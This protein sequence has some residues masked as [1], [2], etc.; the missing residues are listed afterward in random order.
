[1]GNFEFVQIYVNCQRFEMKSDRRFTNGLKI[2]LDSS[3]NFT[4]ITMKRSILFIWS[5]L[6][7][8]LFCTFTE[9]KMVKFFYLKITG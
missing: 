3:F 8:F 7:L 4:L 5:I 9:N 2:M 1:M 6:M